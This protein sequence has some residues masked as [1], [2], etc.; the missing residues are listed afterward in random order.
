MLIVSS[1]IASVPVRAQAGERYFPETGHTLSGEYLTFYTSIPNP[2][3][4]YGFP[5]TEPFYQESFGL[6]VQFFQKARFEFHPDNPAGQR[7]VLTNLG[8]YTHDKGS[9]V[10]LT[11]YAGGCKIFSSEVDHR[12]PVCY[13]FLDFYQ[14]NGGPDQFGLPISGM[15]MQS[16]YIMQYFE[17]ARL[18]WHPELPAGENITIGNLGEIYFNLL[19]LDPSRL[20][21]ED[22]PGNNLVREPV[23][24]VPRAFVSSAVV[25]NGEEQTVYV[26]VQDQNNV[27]I[28]NAGVTGS[29]ILPNSIAV[30]LEL[31]VTNADGIS[32]YSFRVQSGDQT[33]M[34]T[35]I[36]EV[37]TEEG[38]QTFRTSFR[39]WY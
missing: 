1:G 13:S 27:P 4:V 14:A 16:G 26:T 6:Q 35:V 5:I 39:I 25:G 29:V 15:E 36:I 28:P 20:F 12:Y 31:P 10:Q 8:E 2:E 32:Q 7:I 17:N 18:E 34:A 30:P 33:G 37:A 11:T 22:G 9:P 19:H 3:E 21:P 38:S 24:V 23:T